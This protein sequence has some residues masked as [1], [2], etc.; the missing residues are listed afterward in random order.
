ML[1]SSGDWR[2]SLGRKE[3]KM[4]MQ[5]RI[6]WTVVQFNSTHSESPALLEIRLCSNSSS[7][8]FWF[9]ICSQSEMRN[10]AA[11]DRFR[12]RR[13]CA[14]SEFHAQG[15]EMHGRTLWPATDGSQYFVGGGMDPRTAILFTE[16]LGQTFLNWHLGH[17]CRA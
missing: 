17:T 2:P 6:S 12:G 1:T 16:E 3:R 14:N 7:W 5:C 4:Q 13:L 9:G 10:S 11:A 8:D 15:F